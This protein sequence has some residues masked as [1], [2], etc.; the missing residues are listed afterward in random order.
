MARKICKTIDRSEI[1]P[2]ARL[3]TKRR[4]EQQDI[5]SPANEPQAASDHF[6]NYPTYLFSGTMVLQKDSFV[7]DSTMQQDGAIN[8]HFHSAVWASVDMWGDVYCVSF[9]CFS[10]L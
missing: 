3:R 7:S 6:N 5:D 4:Y 10:F 9:L 2:L 8:D 1:D